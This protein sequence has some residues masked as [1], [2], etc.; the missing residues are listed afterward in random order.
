M[1]DA[2]DMM[3]PTA[4]F[5]SP[6]VGF[7]LSYIQCRTFISASPTAPI[8]HRERHVDTVSDG[9]SLDDHGSNQATGYHG[10]GT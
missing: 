10:S 9:L 2:V 1:S 3:A 8:S 5:N 7:G 4:C 6:A